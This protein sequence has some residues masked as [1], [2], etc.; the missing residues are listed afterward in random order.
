ML[1]PAPRRLDCPRVLRTGICCKPCSANRAARA[2]QCCALAVIQRGESTLC[3]P[4]TT[5]LQSHQCGEAHLDTCKWCMPRCCVYVDTYLLVWALVNSTLFMCAL[6]CCDVL[7]KWAGVWWHAAP[8][9]LS[10]GLADAR[11]LLLILLSIQAV[12]MRVSSWSVVGLHSLLYAL[13]PG[14]DSPGLVVFAAA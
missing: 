1:A 9:K 7:E 2:T 13:L 12:I 8:P 11:C 4:T 10:Y 6:S 3:S 14:V 5:S